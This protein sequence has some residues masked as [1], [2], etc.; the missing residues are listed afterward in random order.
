MAIDEKLN[1]RFRKALANAPDLPDIKEQ[2]MMS[3]VCFMLSGN[4]VGGA[5]RT[6]EG[7]GRFMFRL[8]KENDEEGHA[9]PGA[10]PM[11]MGGRRMRGFFF[12]DEADCTAKVMKVW[13]GRALDHARSLPPK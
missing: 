6:K 11:E 12:V 7:V 4:M 8:G 13:L 2:K 3:G 1:E 5:D 10:Q 9:L